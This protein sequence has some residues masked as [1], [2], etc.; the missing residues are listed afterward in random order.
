MSAHAGSPSW[1]TADALL[2]MPRGRIRRELVRGEVRELPL[3]GAGEG[4]MLARLS[5]E[6]SDHVDR[7]DLGQ[8]Y[9]AGTGFQLAAHPDTVLAPAVSFVRRERLAGRPPSGGY[10]PGAPELVVEVVSPSASPD[11]IRAKAADWLASGCR[12]VVL[13]NLDDRTVHVCRPHNETAL[14]TGDDELDGGD[15]LPGWCLPVRRIFS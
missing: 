3:R 6:M 8:V 2:R 7:H 11:V 15:V 14:L 13:V 10:F 12:M 5:M 4:A 1:I 9:A